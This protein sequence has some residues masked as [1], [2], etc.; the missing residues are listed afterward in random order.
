MAEERSRFPDDGERPAPSAAQHPG[1]P[2]VI[3]FSEPPDRAP[4]GPSEFVAFA[5]PGLESEVPGRSPLTFTAAAP[6]P[7]A[8]IPAPVPE[9][10]PD[11]VGWTATSHSSATQ[12]LVSQE[13]WM[14]PTVAS[15]S[16]AV[17]NLA[18][19]RPRVIV[20][21]AAVA[22]VT[23]ASVTAITLTT[24]HAHTTVSFSESPSESA[25]GR[26]PT[27]V[28]QAPSAPGTAAAYSQAVARDLAPLEVDYAELNRA[29][30]AQDGPACRAAASSLRQDSNALLFDL[31]ASR[32]PQALA[33]ADGLLRQALSRNAEG[34]AQ[35]IA[36][37][38]DGSADQ[39]NRAV[40]TLAS[41]DTLMSQAARTLGQVTASAAPAP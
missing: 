30:A 14:A 8:P 29:C 18:A 21:L 27:T 9:A 16:S 22:I 7:S 15:R 33:A 40:V 2:V 19:H 38:D 20:T 28:P 13:V 24:R 10:P 23:M 6:D 37:L 41:A 11:A 31:D 12:A 3:R 25:A 17:S 39:V 35:L 36:G 4:A 1:E 26:Q 34:A 5:E 32:P